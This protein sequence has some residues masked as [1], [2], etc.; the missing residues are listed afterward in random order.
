[1]HALKFL[2]GIEFQSAWGILRLSMGILG[3][4]RLA[5][6]S[7]W[8]RKMVRRASWSLHRWHLDKSRVWRRK[9]CFRGQQNYL[10]DIGVRAIIEQEPPVEFP[11]TARSGREPCYSLTARQGQLC[12]FT[13]LV[14][15]MWPGH[16]REAFFPS[17]DAAVEWGLASLSSC[18][19]M[20]LVV[21]FETISDDFYCHGSWLLQ[22]NQVMLMF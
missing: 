11:F 16:F 5:S 2:F 13:T 15:C 8:T 7:R 17:R 21:R 10:T 18:L 4:L 6:H 19:T 3:H 9:W 12:S 1:M 22:N 14:T 20:S